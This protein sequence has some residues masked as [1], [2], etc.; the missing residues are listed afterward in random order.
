MVTNRMTCLNTSFLLINVLKRMG[1]ESITPFHHITIIYKLFFKFQSIT[2]S[3]LGY[4][5][6]NINTRLYIF[7]HVSINVE[8]IFI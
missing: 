6:N 4:K 7:E 1:L 8:Y 5:N 3:E 2:N